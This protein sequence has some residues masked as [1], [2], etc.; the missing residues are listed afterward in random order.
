[1]HKACP[2]FQA[3]AARKADMAA[4]LRQRVF[5]G[6]FRLGQQGLGGGARSRIYA[7]N[8]KRAHR[9][10]VGQR[11]I[12]QPD[13]AHK[14]F[15]YLVGQQARPQGVHPWQQQGIAPSGHMAEA[16]AGFAVFTQGGGQGSINNLN[17]QKLFW[18]QAS[19]L[20]STMGSD[21]EF[22]AMTQA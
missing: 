10:V 3:C 15:L 14:G 17:P 5:Q 1:M 6:V 18:K 22:S 4:L 19:I 12:A 2:F 11:R 16:V 9:A 21:Q 13:L 20:G 7:G 8:A